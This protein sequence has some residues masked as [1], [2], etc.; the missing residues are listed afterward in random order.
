MLKNVKRIIDLYLISPT[1]W[2]F[3]IR[4]RRFSV[5]PKTVIPRTFIQFV[6][7]VFV[8]FH[9]V[10]ILLLEKLITWTSVASGIS[11]KSGQFYFLWSIVWLFV[12]FCGIKTWIVTEIGYST[13]ILVYSIF[14]SI[15]L[16][17]LLALI[18][19]IPTLL[20]SRSF[21]LHQ[22]IRAIHEIFLIGDFGRSFVLT[23]VEGW[24]LILYSKWRMSAFIMY[25]ALVFIG[26]FYVEELVYFW[27]LLIYLT[28]YLSRV[29]LKIFTNIV[30]IK[31][32]RYTILEQEYVD[33]LMKYFLRTHSSSFYIRRKKKNGDVNKKNFHSSARGLCPD[34]KGVPKILFESLTGKS[35][36]DYKF[37]FL[38]EAAKENVHRYGKN[39]T[40]NGDTYRAMPEEIKFIEGYSAA[41]GIKEPNTFSS[42]AGSLFR[43]FTET[44]YRSANKVIRSKPFIFS[45]TAVTVAVTGCVVAKVGYGVPIDPL[46]GEMYLLGGK[47]SRMHND[48]ALS[49]NPV[50]QSDPFLN[51]WPKLQMV[52]KTDGLSPEV[53][54][55]YKQK[56]KISAEASDAIRQEIERKLHDRS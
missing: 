14:Y 38:T 28:A 35:P 25:Y 1:Q 29:I 50:L 46:T 5:K 6:I 53:A 7:A 47:Y 3:S 55:S 51:S 16:T 54:E 8:T 45:F 26:M 34:A 19:F 37:K 36:N 33:L 22:E 48:V 30:P 4:R 43:E 41:A 23:I 52:L 17:L 10:L 42:H 39:F 18:A 40:I 13:D 27:L 11:F 44:G 49:W 24:S 21:F 20:L 15:G 9:G 12:R 2:Q 32:G 56:F 31:S